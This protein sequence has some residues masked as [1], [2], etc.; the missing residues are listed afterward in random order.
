M[1]GRSDS[2]IGTAQDAEDPLESGKIDPGEF[3]PG[4]NDEFAV[5]NADGKLVERKLGAYFGWRGKE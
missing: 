1:Q 4:P 2:L 5:F 3:S